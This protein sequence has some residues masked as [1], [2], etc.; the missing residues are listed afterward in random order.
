V[1]LF[2][3]KSL[4]SGWEFG[5][6]KTLINANEYVL[7]HSKLWS[8]HWPNV[9]QVVARLKEM[10]PEPE[11]PPDPLKDPD[12]K[13][14]IIK[15]L[16]CYCPGGYMWK[17][18]RTRLPESRLND[19]CESIFQAVQGCDRCGQEFNCGWRCLGGTHGICSK[20][21]YK[22]GCLFTL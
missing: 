3:H 12:V 17:F 2:M 18:M 19:R 1:H 6:G 7:L 5:P 21:I 11:P 16:G 4:F 20:C 10:Q 14:H 9:E 15:A 13:P 8:R 22:N